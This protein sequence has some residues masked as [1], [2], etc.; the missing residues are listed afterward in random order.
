MPPIPPGPTGAAR[1]DYWHPSSL[2]VAHPVARAPALLLIGSPPADSSHEIPP[3]PGFARNEHASLACRGPSH[4]R[5]STSSSGSVERIAS[6]IA[7]RIPGGAV[8]RTTVKAV[9][10]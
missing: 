9:P 8:S 10:Q 7:P 2:S 3:T 5:S 6:D 4:L 1:H